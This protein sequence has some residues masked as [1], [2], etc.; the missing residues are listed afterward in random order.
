M[1]QFVFPESLYVK[2]ICSWSE[3]LPV[4]QVH[5]VKKSMTLNLTTYQITLANLDALCSGITLPQSQYRRIR[6]LK[7]H[8]TTSNHIADTPMI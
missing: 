6:E 3:M 2:G 7:G 1:T 8:K 5:G 4:F